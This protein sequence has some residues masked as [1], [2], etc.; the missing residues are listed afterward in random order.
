MY[1]YFLFYVVF[2]IFAHYFNIYRFNMQHNY[3][4]EQK[5]INNFFIFYVVFL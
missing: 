4:F 1:L 2:F 5:I 3:K